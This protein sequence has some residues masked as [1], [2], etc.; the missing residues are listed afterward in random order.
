[1]EYDHDYK[2]SPDSPE[3]DLCGEE[4]TPP[5]VAGLH[6]KDGTLLATG[7]V[8]VV[9]GGRGDYVEFTHAQINWDNFYIP[10]DQQWRQTLRWRDK[11]YYDEHRS[12]G[13]SKVMLYDQK[14]VVTYA[15][16]KVGLLYIS[17]E[18]I[19]EKVE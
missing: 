10:G 3:C 16:Y 11:V 4:H 5:E 12:C 2:W 6:A 17:P 1:M 8:R 15:D 13:K 7:Y 18:D 19:V 9:H 14:R